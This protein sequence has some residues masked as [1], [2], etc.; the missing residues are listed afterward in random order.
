VTWELRELDGDLRG[1]SP[2]GPLRVKA[3]FA[4]ASGGR[5]ELKG[6]VALD[7]DVDLELELEEVALAPVTAY[8]GDG[9]Q[10]AGRVSGELELEGPARSPDRIAA[11]LALRDADVRF[12][13]IS[14]RGPLRVEAD[15][16]GGLAAPSG[17]FDIDATQAELVWRALCK[18]GRNLG[19]RDGRACAGRAACR[20]RRSK[21]QVRRWT[22]PR[23]EQRRMR[24]DV[25]ASPSPRRLEALV[26][27]EGW[28]LRPPRAG[29]LA[30]R[31][32]TQLHGRIEL[33]KV[34]A[35]SPRGG[36]L[37]RGALLGE[38][39]V[40]AR[41]SSWWRPTRAFAT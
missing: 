1:E 14:L 17:S 24:I 39:R 38:A 41:G 3:S 16:A 15:L 18:A 8:L 35:A 9:T 25:R 21:L 12:D 7:G 27:L 20:I 33:D 40:P 34:R 6:T 5:A 36:T 37:V 13:E 28:Q 2:R 31:R 29:A 11:R 19:D 10:L 26:L 22:R 4:L 32:P 30:R 23:A